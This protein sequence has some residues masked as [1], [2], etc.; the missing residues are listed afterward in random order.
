[1]RKFKTTLSVAFAALV[2]VAC[3]TTPQGQQSSDV[4]VAP[5]WNQLER[6]NPVL[7]M[8]ASAGVEHDWWRHFG[9]PMLDALIA[10]AIANNKSLQIAVARIEEARANRGIARSRLFPEVT[11]A[12]SVQRGNQGFQTLDQ[13]F[14]A[15]QVTID[16]SW[17]ADLFG[18]NQARTAEAGAI[19][20]SEEAAMQ[21]VQVALLAEVARNYFDVRN[22]ER[23]IVLTEQNSRPSR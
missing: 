2:L 8:N 20:Q 16:A 11:G 9:D 10:E 18:R 19:L 21:A 15:A 5:S 14:N 4:A 7:A 23:Q 6:A 1:M 17:E 13:T 3:A 22:F 12:A